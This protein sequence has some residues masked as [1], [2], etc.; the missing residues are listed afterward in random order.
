MTKGRQPLVTISP[1][2]VCVS[3][4]SRR[5]ERSYPRSANSNMIDRHVQ[6]QQ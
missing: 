6:K 5:L 2:R 3:S 4:R 1:V